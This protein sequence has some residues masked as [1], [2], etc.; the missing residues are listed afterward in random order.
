MRELAKRR[1]A[2]LIVVLGVLVVLAL[3]ATTFAT[4]QTTE[5]HIARNYL[6]TVRARLLAQSGQEDASA[7]LRGFF[8][9]RAFDRT[10]EGRSWK[11]WGDDLTE[12]REPGTYPI[13]KALSPSFAVED[14]AIQDPRDPNVAAKLVTVLV[15][16]S[17]ERRGFSGLHESGTYALHGDHYVLRVTDLSGRI[18][19]NDGIDRMADGSSWENPGVTQNL[20]R[21]LNLLGRSDTINITDLGDKILRNRPPNGYAHMNEILK[22]VDYDETQFARFRDFVTVHAWVDR[23]VANPVPLSSLADARHAEAPP[24]GRGFQYYRGS[25]PVY[26]FGSESGGSKDASGAPLAYTLDAMPAVPGNMARPDQMQ[27]ACIYGLDVLN[28]QWI[29]IVSRAPV[30]VNTAPRE[31]LMALLGDLRG[32]FLTDR[33]RNNPSYFGDL[34]TSFKKWNSF[35]PADTEGDEYG[36]LAETQ[37]ILFPS[38]TKDSNSIYSDDIA[39]EIIACRSGRTGP[40]GFNYDPQ[41]CAFGGAFRNWAQ[42]Y[43]FIDN[44]VDIQVLRDTRADLWHD[45]NID[46]PAG[47]Q[48]ATG[49]SNLNPSDLQRLHATR[50]IADTIKANFN[51]NL[52]LNELNPD[53]NLHL[54]VDKTDLIVNSTE[55]SFL[56]TGYFEVESLGRVLRP[57]NGGTDAFAAENQIVAQAKIT[58]IYRFYDL[59]RE[60][61]QSQFYAGEFGDRGGAFET[62]N[63]RSVEVGPEPDNGRA[64]TENEWGGYV[65][66]PTVGGISCSSP[67]LRKPKDAL[68]TTIDHQGTG[69]LDS[70]MH[71]HFQLDFDAHHHIVDPLEIAS[72][73]LP[74]DDP[75]ENWADPGVTHAGPYDPTDGPDPDSPTQSHRLA[76][77]FRLTGTSTTPSLTPFPPSDL[78]ID[79]GYMERHAAAAYYVRK[80]GEALWNFNTENARG[81]ISFWVKPSFDPE[82]TGK[83]RT[84]FDMSK[85]HF[86]CNARVHVWPW[87]VWFF[88]SHYSRYDEATEVPKYR[89]NNTYYYQPTSL[90]FGHK[91]WHDLDPGDKASRFGNFTYSLN[92][93]GHGACWRQG[94]SVLRGRKWVNVTF[95]WYLWGQ[96]DTANRTSRLY[97][98][99][100][101]WHT[102]PARLGFTAMTGQ[103]AGQD[104]INDFEVH[105]QGDEPNQLRLGAPSMICRAAQVSATNQAY[106]GNQ[107]NDFTI[108]EF[109]VWTLRG[110]ADSPEQHRPLTHWWRGRYY[111]PDRDEGRFTSQRI[112]LRPATARNL[113]RPGGASPG[114]SPGLP[115]PSPSGPA[116]LDRPVVRILGLAWTWFGEETTIVEE[117]G[118]PPELRRA[119]FNYNTPEGIAGE[120]VRPKVTMSV[121]DGSTTF[122]PYDDDAF[123][124]ARDQDGE[125]LELRDPTDFRY[126]AQFVLQEADFSAVLVA[127]PV[128]DDV[129]IFWDDGQPHVISYTYDNRSF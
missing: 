27:A 85:Y 96:T 128:L 24:A 6:D 26:R 80:G 93:E 47:G 103:A 64:P 114:P 94:K 104:R 4:L 82:R 43:K 42:F 119:L 39:D 107:S 44:L 109:Y 98:N 37:P 78:R 38:G 29:E 101:T 67:G 13:E 92:H 62:N 84:I 61:S 87:S 12:T 117:S 1:G 105:D 71:A 112:S 108:D 60:T 19:L 30:N 70:Q 7:R 113:P 102:D 14:E 81:L 83:I 32:F 99:G 18:H 126:V 41:A 121:R 17:A 125:I 55:F 52:H 115:A 89:S 88:P 25:P 77:S 34:Y 72:R 91:Q 122:G 120:D 111:K 106:R 53:H 90:S 33:R 49:Y 28:P 66:L 57:Q 16:G 45:Y 2:V 9:F 8:P 124:A 97:I 63:N 15:N 65:A 74:D 58:A 59:H 21:I 116:F 110:S 100:S 86:P 11:Y 69:H 22:A 73:T 20:K 46:G 3:L 79:G 54:I 23:N 35:S 95:W 40:K 51:P 76:R 31:V 10:N 75:V 123:S 129:T 48:D 50:A 36:Y 56:P 118:Q 127:T 5:R 68:W